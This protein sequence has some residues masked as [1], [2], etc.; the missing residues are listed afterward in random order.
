MVY[1]YLI[2][3]YLIKWFI[4]IILCSIIYIKY[5]VFIINI[6]IICNENFL[7]F[8]IIIIIFI[9]ILVYFEIIFKKFI[10]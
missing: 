5:V 7:E 1:F 9:N 2:Y 6:G 4:V 10:K 3:N 8:E